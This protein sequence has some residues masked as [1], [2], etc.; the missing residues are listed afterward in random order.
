MQPAVFFDRDGTLNVEKAYLFRT[1]DWEW[2]P[3]AKETLAALK[4]AGYARICV[5][6]QSGIGRGYYTQKD[7]ENLHAFVQEELGENRLEGFYVC[8]HAPHTSHASQDASFAQECQCRKPSPYLLEKAAHEHHL[9]LARSWMVGDKASD[10]GA[11]LAAGC[12]S[13]L[14]E[15]G[16]GLLEKTKALALYPH[17]EAEGRLFVVPG[18]QEVLRCIVEH[19]RS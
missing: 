8:P 3:Y 19:Y 9:D 7:V 10:V 6:N 5:S 18:L 12:R 2:L 14:V 1:E 11:G 16:Y 15:T 17:A 13:I 4:Q